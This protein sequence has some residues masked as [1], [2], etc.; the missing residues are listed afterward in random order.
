MVGPWESIF[1][2]QSSDCPTSEGIS[3]NMHEALFIA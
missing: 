3:I 2:G 1:G